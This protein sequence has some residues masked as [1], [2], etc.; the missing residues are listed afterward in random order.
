VNTGGRV[1]RE[2]TPPRKGYHA[3]AREV[4]W[5]MLR[6]TSSPVRAEL[7]G[8]TDA[9]ELEMF[10][11]DTFRRRWR[12]LRDTT[13]R[14]YADRVKARLLARGFEDRRSGDRPSAWPHD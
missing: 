13:A 1:I 3:E 4:L 10:S 5:M 9:V 2:S 12:F 6:D 14:R 11:G 8:L 7:V